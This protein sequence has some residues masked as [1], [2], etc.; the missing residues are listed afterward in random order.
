MGNLT[1]C[2]C[3]IF[4]RAAIRPPDWNAV[5]DGNNGDDFRIGLQVTPGQGKGKGANKVSN[6]LC[7]S[8]ER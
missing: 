4:Q 7:V 8:N 5:F 2:M 1:V 6:T 3:V